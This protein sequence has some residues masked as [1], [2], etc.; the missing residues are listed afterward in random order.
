MES[1]CR[2]DSRLTIPRRMTSIVSSFRMT[3]K[4]ISGGMVVRVAI[5]EMFELSTRVMGEAVAMP[6]FAGGPGGAAAAAVSSRPSRATWTAKT[7][8]I[9]R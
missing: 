2:L 1:E 8:S 7:N 3:S 5:C 9:D 4:R 6:I